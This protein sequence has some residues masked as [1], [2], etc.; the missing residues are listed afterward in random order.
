MIE[1]RATE[2][3]SNRSAR[4]AACQRLMCARSCAMDREQRVGG[5]SLA[6]GGGSGAHAGGGREARGTR[7]LWA[8]AVMLSV[9]ALGVVAST[10]GVAHAVASRLA[11]PP[12]I[13]ATIDLERVING[14][15]ERWAKERELE[16]LKRKY[17]DDLK[18]RES[19]LKTESELINVMAP[20]PQREERAEGFEEK[21]VDG[22]VR[23][24]LFERRLE[25]RRTQ[26]FASMYK[27]IL[28]ASAGLAEA[29]GYGLILSADDTLQIPETAKTAQ[30]ARAVIASRRVIFQSRSLDVTEDLITLM[31][32]QWIA[33]GGA[34]PDKS[35]PAGTI[36]QPSKA[37]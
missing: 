4:W 26:M 33:E 36:P 34:A 13:V 18:R 19:E 10:S 2:R 21:A 28:K 15:H 16:V 8:M 37:R 29:N 5:V 35:L 6:G 7:G 27:S 22:R 17:E 12:T 24:E 23:S 1:P 30:E 11:P 20:G 3:P 9:A 31:N 25:A 14:L 32:N